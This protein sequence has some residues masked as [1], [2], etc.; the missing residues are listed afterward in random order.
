MFSNYKEPAIQPTV[1]LTIFDR[2]PLRK[3]LLPIRFQIIA[4]K[5]EKIGF[6]M[7]VNSKSIF[8]HP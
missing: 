7:L 5:P 4:A 8:L 6:T 1:W 3:L 2:I